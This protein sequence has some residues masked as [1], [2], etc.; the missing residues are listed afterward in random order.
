ML[1]IGAACWR[2]E[3]EEARPIIS[4]LLVGRVRFKPLE[5]FGSWEMTGEGTL[6]GLV[7]GG[8]VPNGLASPSIPSW[9][10]IARFLESMRRLRDATGL[11]A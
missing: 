6:S 5:A 3:V 4:R 8:V 10:Q 11:V 2:S 9:N 7:T 1:T